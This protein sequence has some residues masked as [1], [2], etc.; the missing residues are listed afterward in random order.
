[1]NASEGERRC[2]FCGLPRS[3]TGPLVQG[4]P[5]GNKV[6]I[7]GDCCIRGTNYLDEWHRRKRE[8]IDRPDPALARLRLADTGTG[9]AVGDRID[10][11]AHKKGEQGRRD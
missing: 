10:T 4:G 11:D 1:M 3:V 6:F 7:C 8:E 9:E 5:R 2:G